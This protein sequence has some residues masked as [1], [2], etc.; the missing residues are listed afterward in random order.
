M[1]PFVS[2][3]VRAAAVAAA[4]L[5]LQAC[6]QDESGD[7]APPDY[8]IAKLRKSQGKWRFG[9]TDTI[10]IDF[11][12]RIDTAALAATFD[13]DEGVASRFQGQSRLLVF[14]SHTGAGAP[15]FTIN[16]P[17]TATLAGL[18]DLR[19]NSRPASTLEFEPYYWADGDFIDG[20]FKGF[21]SLFA[22]DSTWADGSAFSDTLISEGNLDAK[23]NGATVDYSDIKL[24]RLMPPDT[25]RISLSCPRSVNMKLQA[26]GPFDPA[27]ADSL[28]LKFDFD[29]ARASDSTLS[30]G[31]ASVQVA[32]D[33]GV[34]D[35]SLGNPSLPGIYAV[36]VSLTALD[37][38]AFYRLETSLHRKKRP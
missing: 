4:A 36:R 24:I 20:D 11:S 8:T 14:G 17:F 28:L 29:K 22:T 3:P 37:K 31:S 10:A 30:R 7:K 25:F 35:D 15:N 26:A 12:E 16:A 21:D 19:G 13:P 2:V 27:K 38:E 5:L 6:I 33:Y 9:V 1:V 23:T 32:A 34:H 18:R